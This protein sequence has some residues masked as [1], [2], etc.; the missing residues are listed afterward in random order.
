MRRY[1]EDIDARLDKVIHDVEQSKARINELKGRNVTG[2]SAQVQRVIDDDYSILGG[3]L[4]LHLR[5]KII[6]H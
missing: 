6:E 4:D 2:N 3:H 5:K 1:E